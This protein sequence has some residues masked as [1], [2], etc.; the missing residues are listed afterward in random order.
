MPPVKSTV[1]LEKVGF[2]R[3]AALTSPAR[4]D[5]TIAAWARS[6]GLFCSARSI[7]CSRVRLAIEPAATASHKAGQSIRGN[8][9]QLGIEAPQGTARAASRNH[10]K[11][12]EGELFRGAVSSS[13]P[14]HADCPHGTFLARGGGRAGRGARGREPAG[15]RGRR[16]EG[17]DRKK[18][19]NAENAE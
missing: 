10:K 5:S 9:P 8:L 15:T 17:R 7:P 2:G 19:E 6:P 11:S 12:H 16:S 13:H 3:S 1:P 14:S 18:G 4:V